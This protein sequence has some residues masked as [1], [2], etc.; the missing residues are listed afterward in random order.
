M[1]V[2]VEDKT[3]LASYFII[4]SAT[5]GV[6]AK[7]IINYVEDE[8]A[9][10]N[11]EPIGKDTNNG[12]AWVILDYGDIMVHIMDREVREFYDLEKL[13]VEEDNTYEFSG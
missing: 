7:G 1:V 9:K 10:H 12:T 4:A 6:Q 8:M 11:L 2:D 5:S 13:W 3:T